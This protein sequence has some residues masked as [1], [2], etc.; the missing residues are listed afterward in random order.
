MNAKITRFTQTVNFVGNNQIITTSHIRKISTRVTMN[1][2]SAD[3]GLTGVQSCLLLLVFYSTSQRQF[4]EIQQ[5]ILYYTNTNN[6][7]IN[8][9]I[10]VYFSGIFCFSSYINSQTLAESIAD[11]RQ[12][13]LTKQELERVCNTD[14]KKLCLLNYQMT[15]ANSKATFFT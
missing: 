11:K 1:E 8:W 4:L 6:I 15:R 5:D 13:L 12:N 10:M 9:H 7:I 14:I 3:N 2:L